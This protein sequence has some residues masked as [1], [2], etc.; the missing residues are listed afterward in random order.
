[1]KRKPI[2][3]NDTGIVLNLKDLA[4]NLPVEVFSAIRLQG[5]VPTIPVFFN[6]DKVIEYC[7]EPLRLNPDLEG[8]FL[9]AS[10]RVL[11]NYAVMIDGL[12]SKDS[13]G[14]PSLQDENAE[15]IRFQPFFLGPADANNQT[16]H[17]K[18]LFERGLHFSGVITPTNVRLSCVCNL[19]RKPFNLHSFHAGFSNGQYFYSADSSRTLFVR[20]GDIENMPGQLQKEIDS[21]KLNTVESALPRP[22]NGSGPFKYYNPFRC[23]HCRAAYIDFETYPEIR[24]TEYYGNTYVN[25]NAQ[26]FKQ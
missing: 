10:I 4:N 13:T 12:I 20:Y 22:D 1:M 15:A 8:Q 23:P 3:G 2:T 6:N 9:H 14:A 18:G 19:C 26:K 7:I 16:L 24:P 5:A 25:Q 11:E 17:G 21:K